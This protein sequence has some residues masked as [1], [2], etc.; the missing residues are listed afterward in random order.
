VAEAACH[1]QFCRRQ[2]VRHARG[3]RDG[4]LAVVLVVDQQHGQ[5]DLSDDMADVVVRR[6]PPDATFDRRDKGRR[7]AP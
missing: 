2:G 7:A 1:H 5:A 3:F 4:H 6:R